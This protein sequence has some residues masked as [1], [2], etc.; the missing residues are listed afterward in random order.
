MKGTGHIEDRWQK[1]V[2]LP[3]GGRK[4]E[5]TSR[6]RV[7]LRWRVRYVPVGGKEKSRSFALK[8][9][10]QAFLITVRAQMQQDAYIDPALGNVTLRRYAGEWLEGQTFAATT[11][12]RVDQRLRNHIL[13]KL[14]DRTLT[15]LSHDP[16]GIQS[17]LRGLKGPD[18]RPL[19]P[20]HARAVLANL[21]SIFSAAVD[22]NRIGRNPCRVQTVKAPRIVKKKIVPWTRAEVDAAQAALPER[23]RVLADI[24]SLLGLRQGEAFALSPADVS[25]LRREVHVR[26]Q[27]RIVGSKL[28]FAPPKGGK[29]RTVPLS[30]TLA[31][32]LNLHAEAFPPVAVTLPWLDPK[33]PPVT[34]R[35]YVTTTAG[36][37]LDRAY[38][39]RLWREARAA[40]GLPPTRDN[41]F[42]V[43][44]HTFASVLIAGGASIRA[45]S[46]YLGHE[47]PG[48]TLRVYSHLM[49]GADDKA[50]LA[51]ENALSES[52]DGPQTAPSPGGSYPQKAEPQVRALRRSV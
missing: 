25:F 22:N 5:P 10:A 14:G 30:P 4:K 40:A 11:R 48:F 32:R 33:G 39:H 9:D 29:E 37:A 7:G 42:H 47:D 31:D 12:E 28:C 35:L 19:A 27:V 38:F 1:Y 45:V 49:P 3:G 46:E 13:P 36:N 52:S 50:R 43:L 23:Y 18:G 16:A 20:G 34:A 17:W 26:R 6:A 15:Q 24:G 51:L 2:E 41:G 8:D 44:R 21:S